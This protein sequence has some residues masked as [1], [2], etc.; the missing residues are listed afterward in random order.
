MADCLHLL[1]LALTLTD[2]AFVQATNI[3]SGSELSPLWLLAAASPW[4]RALQRFFVYRMSWNLGVLLVFALLVRHATTTGLLHMLED[5]LL[6]AVLCQVHLLNNVG[7]RQRPDLVFFNSFLIAFITSL[8]APDLS[9]S[10]LFVLHAVLLVPALQV[11]ALSARTGNLPPGIARTLLL[12]SLPR[13]L[14]LGGLTALVFVAWP[15]DFQRKGWLEDSLA[16]REHLQAGFSEQ[17]QLDHELPMHLGTEVVMRI[18]PSSGRA[19]DVP[20]HWRGIAFSVFDGSSWRQQGARHFG[21]RLATDV[22]WELHADGSWRRGPATSPGSLR[23]RLEQ[24]SGKRLFSPMPACELRLATSAG[25]LLDPLSYGVLAVL[26]LHDAPPGPI[27]YQLQLGGPHRLPVTARVRKH[28]VAL[29]DAAM[30]QFVHDLAARLL[31]ENGPDADPVSLAYA[32]CCWLQKHRRYQLPGGPGFARNLGEFLVGSGAGHCEYFA[33]ALA[34]LLR[35]QNVP[36]RLVGGYLAHEWDAD[37]DTTVVRARDA[38][39]WVETLLADGSW[40]TF[41]PTP[42]SSVLPETDT[43]SWWDATSTWLEQRWN[44]VVGFDPAARE[45]LFAALCNLPATVLQLAASQPLTLAGVLT[46]LVALYYVRRRRRQSLPAIVAFV[47]ATRA[48][49][50]TQRPGET[51]RDLLARATTAA[52]PPVRLAALQAAARQ[53]ETVRYGGARGVNR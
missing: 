3:V 41:D 43:Q 20:L 49:G 11:N 48:A 2:L 1:L 6:L 22:A 8:F 51:P 10:L 29:P 25:L 30:P 53:H 36:C 7:E 50:L 21:S 16:L 45:R 17:I 34:L 28:L 23:V 27:D 26:R 39:A 44:D 47:D 9:W 5:G 24:G 31:Q 35:L 15:R 52:I 18:E 42:P 19:E 38:H 40:L 13:T 4:L 14:A 46:M 32:G 12:D 37:T 33:T